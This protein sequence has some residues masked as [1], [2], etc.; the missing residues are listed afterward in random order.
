MDLFQRNPDDSAETMPMQALD[1]LSLEGWL[2]DCPCENH[3][4]LLGVQFAAIFSFVG[5][6]VDCPK[7]DA[8][9]YRSFPRRLVGGI[10]TEATTVIR[11]MT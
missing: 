6:C 9:Q 10:S 2:E 11:S 7:K 1:E 5:V 3:V 8:M 4:L